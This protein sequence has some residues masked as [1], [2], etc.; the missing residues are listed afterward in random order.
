MA[1]EASEKE[2]FTIS[3][4]YQSDILMTTKSL[5]ASFTSCWVHVWL[6]HVKREARMKVHGEVEGKGRDDRNTQVLGHLNLLFP[7]TRMFFLPQIYLPSS[8][9]VT[10]LSGIAS[11]RHYSLSYP[12]LISRD[13]FV[14]SCLQTCTH[15]LCLVHD[16]ARKSG[17]LSGTRWL[18]LS[19]LFHFPKFSES[20][21]YIPSSSF[22]K[23][24]Y[25]SNK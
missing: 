10:T 16:S 4:P 23:I 19:K 2:Q 7:L 12:A 3:Y 11:T 6:D 20:K 17:T 22:K 18:L 25:T 9:H 13:I 21:F 24:L 1:P 5:Q 15:G 8:K 14:E